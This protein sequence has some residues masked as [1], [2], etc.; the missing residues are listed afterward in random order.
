MGAVKQLL[1]WRGKP[2][3]RHVTE[4][5]LAVGLN[6]VVVVTGAAA[7][8]VEAALSGLPVIFVKNEA[9]E[10]GQASSVRAGIQALPDACGAAVFLLS[11]MPQVPAELIQAELTKHSQQNDPI[12]VPRINGQR[13][14]PALFDRITFSDL[15]G[16]TGDTGGRA[17]F[18]RFPVNWLDWE[19]DSPLSDIDTPADYQ[20]LIGES[21]NDG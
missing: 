17:L 13:T 5:A 6:P 10:S 20:R 21:N 16:L 8:E 19:S 9:W 12:I 7:D 11:D 3:V 4:S 15:A 18:E 2:L 14:N 1:P